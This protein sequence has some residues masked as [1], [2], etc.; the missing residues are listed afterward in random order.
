LTIE[1]SEESLRPEILSA[2]HPLHI[3]DIPQRGIIN[4]AQALPTI[5]SLY[6][7]LSNIL[8]HQNLPSPPTTRQITSQTD[9]AF[10]AGPLSYY[11]NQQNSQSELQHLRIFLWLMIVIDSTSQTEEDHQRLG[12]QMQQ[13]QEEQQQQGLQMQQQHDEQQQQQDFFDEGVENQW[14]DLNFDMFFQ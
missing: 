5:A 10:H 2:A 1:L 13:E 9:H 14:G 3:R 6:P 12:P 7:K 4:Q 8:P 11:G